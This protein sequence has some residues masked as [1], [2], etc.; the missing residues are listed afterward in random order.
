MGS[1]AQI[2]ATLDSLQQFATVATVSDEARRNLQ[3]Q[4]TA[5]ARRL[6]QGDVWPGDQVNL[7]V[8][9]EDKWT[10]QF[11]V[12]ANRTIE[13][14]DIEPVNV[15]NVLYSEL[16]GRISE[17]IGRYIRE[18]R[19]RVDV[20]KRVGVL[21]EVA[22]P[23]FYNVSGATL[24]SELIMQAG[25]PNAQSDLDKVVFRRFG[26]TLESGRPRV[27]WESMGLDEL[28]IIPGDEVFVPVKSAF[29]LIRVIGFVLGTA[30]AITLIATRL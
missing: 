10:G 7:T 14:P 11:P 19:V 15:S 25:G 27:V 3:Y 2:Q 23:G 29:V 18:P 21:G 16:E 24:V 5:V 20:L 30:V 9:G 1:R 13:L 6:D 26:Q 17:Q 12:S 22:N 8:S 4:V 28:G